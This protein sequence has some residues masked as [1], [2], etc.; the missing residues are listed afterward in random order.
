MNVLRVGF[1]GTRTANVEATAS[2]FQD[3]LGLEVVRDDPA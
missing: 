3:V 1:V 2:F